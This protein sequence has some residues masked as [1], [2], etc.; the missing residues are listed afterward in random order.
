MER[1]I[2]IALI[3]DHLIFLDALEKYL[4]KVKNFNV[5]YKAT[6]GEDFISYL[7]SSNLN[8]DI[9]LLDIKMKGM[10]GLECLEV[11]TKKYSTVKVIMV[12][13]FHDSLFINEA[14]SKGAMSFIPKDID[15]EV[16][17][18]AI[19]SVNDNGFYVYDELSK[20]LVSNLEKAQ[21]SKYIDDPLKRITKTEFEVLKYLCQGYTANEIGD[22][23]FKSKR[24]IEGHKQRMLDKTQMKN[25]VSLI[26]WAFRKGIVF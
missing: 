17:V 24:T 11:I 23:L 6:S 9:A 12:S 25:T 26:A 4:E 13:M 21:S 18:R 16:L 15:S 14:V 22:M 1:P 20:Y 3:D 5:V 2:S 7:D 19:N 8:V 10:S